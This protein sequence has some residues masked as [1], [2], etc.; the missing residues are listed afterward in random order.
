MQY[1]SVM[2]GYVSI[3]ADLLAAPDQLAPWSNQAWDWIGSLPPKATK[4]G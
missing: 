3:P 1:G 2:R 4:K